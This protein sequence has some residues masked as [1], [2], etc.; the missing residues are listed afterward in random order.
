MEEICF[1]IL[2]K[3][4]DVAIGYDVKTAEMKFNEL[5]SD[6]LV[7]IAKSKGKKVVKV[8]SFKDV[9]D[10]TKGKVTWIPKIEGG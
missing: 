9:L 1:E 2:G 8:K 6:G 4:G 7:P 10:T 5:L 3:K